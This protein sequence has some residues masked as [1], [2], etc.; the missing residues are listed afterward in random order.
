V[1]S[2]VIGGGC[3]ECSDRLI[4]WGC[5]SVWLCEKGSGAGSAVIG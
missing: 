1:G 4:G 3:G 5:V 2:A